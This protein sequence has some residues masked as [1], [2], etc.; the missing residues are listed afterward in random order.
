MVRTILQCES[1]LKRT[2][3]PDTQAVVFRVL[4]IVCACVSERTFENRF[5]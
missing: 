4:V 1:V 2:T 5:S 3:L